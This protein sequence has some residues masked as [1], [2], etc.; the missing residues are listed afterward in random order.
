[1]TEPLLTITA[2]ELNGLA[3]FA[4]NSLIYNHAQTILGWI[5]AVVNN[6]KER[7]PKIVSSEAPVVA[8]EQK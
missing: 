1:M 2:S 5:E 4:K 7:E 6:S 3:D 8:R